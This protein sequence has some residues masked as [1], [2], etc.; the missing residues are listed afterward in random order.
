LTATFDAPVAPSGMPGRAAPSMGISPARRALDKAWWAACA[1]AALLVVVP[2]VWVL[3]GVIQRAASDWHWSVFTQDS[4][5]TGGG[6]ENAILGTLVMLVGVAVLAGLSGIGCGIYLAEIAK[7]SWYTTVLRSASEVLAGIPSIVLGYVGYIALVV[8]LHWGFSVI[9]GLIVLSLLVVPYIAKSTELALNQVPL[10]YREGG[11]ALGM[12]RTMVLRKLV[13]RSAIP[14]MA[15]GLIIALAIS[16]GETA[17][18]LYTVDWSNANPQLTLL[19]PIGYL[20]YAS[21]SFYD[22]PSSAVQA[23][24]YDASLLLVVLVVGLI[25]VARL[26]VRLSQ[27]YAPDRPQGGG[28]AERIAARQRRDGTV[29]TQPPR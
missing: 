29:S 3:V 10:G 14:G 20:T 25:L 27:K 12:P 28:R 18:L 19:H 11:E 6:L 15:T 4:T 5:G 13:V 17:P 7:P 22:D 21:Y 9:A 23:L 8:G 2:V 24:S 16:V 26:V 1:V